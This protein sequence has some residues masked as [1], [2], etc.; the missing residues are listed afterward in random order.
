MRAATL[1]GRKLPEAEFLN[2]LLDNFGIARDRVLL[3]TRSRNTAE[4]AAFTKALVQPKPGERWLEVTSAQHMPRAVGSFRQ[5][6]FPVEAYPVV[7]R[8]RR[9]FGVGIVD[10]ASS[11]LGRL[12]SAVHEWTGLITYWITG[13]SD[14]LLP[15]PTTL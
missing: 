9:H 1:V 11:G 8:T 3:E 5:I 15:G 7:W 4:N 10:L 2:P 12:D 14:A 13:R 6:G